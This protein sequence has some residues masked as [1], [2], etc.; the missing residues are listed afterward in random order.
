MSGPPGIS[1][2]RIPIARMNKV[3]T[4]PSRNARNYEPGLENT[5]VLMNA[6]FNYKKE[7]EKKRN[8]TWKNFLNNK[9]N[10]EPFNWR[11]SFN[12]KNKIK[13][14]NKNNTG[15]RNNVKKNNTTRRVL[16]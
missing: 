16:F 15:K 14:T 3:N 5:T 8:L 2:Y 7:A 9:Q 10:T 11:S 4:E 6:T 12:L 1:K 13:N